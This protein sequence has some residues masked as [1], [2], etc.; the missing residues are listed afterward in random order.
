MLPGVGNKAREQAAKWAEWAIVAL[1]GGS[2]LYEIWVNPGGSWPGPP[3][4]STLLAATIVVPVLFRR[5]YPLA[6]LLLILAAS[7]VQYANGGNA[8]QP[9]FAFI[10]AFYAVAAHS[11][12]R[13]AVLGGVIGAILVL[14]ADFGKLLAGECDG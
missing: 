14:G 3:V 5:R 11:E 8:F 9:F 10:L 6:A 12:L 7:A 1:L 13:R 4:V 2:V